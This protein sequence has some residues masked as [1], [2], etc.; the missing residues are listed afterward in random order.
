MTYRATVEVL[1]T[2]GMLENVS[3]GSLC[4]V[5]AMSAACQR[6]EQKEWR[7][8]LYDKK[9]VGSVSLKIYIFS[10]SISLNRTFTSLRF[11]KDCLRAVTLDKLLTWIMRSP[12]GTY[13]YKTTTKA[14]RIK[15]QS[16]YF[17]VV[18]F[19]IEALFSLSPYQQMSYFNNVLP[20]HL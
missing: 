5:M 12:D 1:Q 2:W 16:I 4:K 6:D 11:T 9:T 7:D 8:H 19:I 13:I 10:K 14:Y 20:R 3:R 17:F 15:I 18:S